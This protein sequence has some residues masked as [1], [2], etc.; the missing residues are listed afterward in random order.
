[1]DVSE[2]RIA[3]AFR[4]EEEDKQ[5]SRRQLPPAYTWTLKAKTKRSSETSAYFQGI[6]ALLRL[7][8]QFAALPLDCRSITHE[9]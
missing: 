3:P 5:E 4:V 1:M 9:I 6:R 7:V 2:E 8:V